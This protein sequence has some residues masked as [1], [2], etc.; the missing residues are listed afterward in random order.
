MKLADFV[1][2]VE[3][4]D[5]K[6]VVGIVTGIEDGL[7]NVVKFAN[8]VW[9]E[10]KGLIEHKTLAAAQVEGAGEHNSHTVVP[11]ED[12]E[13]EPAPVVADSSVSTDS[14]V[15]PVAQTSPVPATV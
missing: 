4:A 6:P 1:R 11:L 12:V 8:G 3:A 15:V 7:I 13:P 2:V 10:V 5:S 14:P 9:T